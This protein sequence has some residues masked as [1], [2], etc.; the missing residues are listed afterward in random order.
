MNN[1]LMTLNGSTYL[2]KFK[3]KTNFSINGLFHMVNIDTNLILKNLYDS[4]GRDNGDN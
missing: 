1:E 2:M 4:E 3:L